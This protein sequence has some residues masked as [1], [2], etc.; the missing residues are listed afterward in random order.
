[1][2][3][4][5]NI[6]RLFWAGKKKDWPCVPMG[7]VDTTIKLPS[8]KTNPHHFITTCERAC[9]EIPLNREWLFYADLISSSVQLI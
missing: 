1:M 8:R 7:Q 5:I 3:A 6:F 4:N 2:F 9:K